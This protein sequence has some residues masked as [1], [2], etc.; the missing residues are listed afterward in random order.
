MTIFRNILLHT[1]CGRLTCTTRDAN[2]NC[3]CHFATMHYKQYQISIIKCTQQI[4]HI[5][6]Q[7]YAACFSRA[8]SSLRKYK[9]CDMSI[10]LLLDSYHNVSIM[11]LNSQTYLGQNVSELFTW[12]SKPDRVQCACHS[13]DLMLGMWYLTGWQIKTNQRSYTFFLIGL[14]R[15]RSK[16]QRFR[17]LISFT[18]AGIIRGKHLKNR[19]RQSRPTSFLT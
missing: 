15:F 18:A 17:R 14:P 11:G 6:T 8:R 5:F 9:V 1:I 2:R 13:T 4:Q 7:I 12:K 10:A 16:L 3:I 19:S